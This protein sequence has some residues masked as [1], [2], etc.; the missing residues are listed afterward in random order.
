MRA[1][2]LLRPLTLTRHRRSLR[3]RLPFGP[4]WITGVRHEGKGSELETMTDLWQMAQMDDDEDF[5]TTYCDCGRYEEWQCANMTKI[6]RF[7]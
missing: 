5:L 3:L 7:I 4:A 6:A 1:R 2:R